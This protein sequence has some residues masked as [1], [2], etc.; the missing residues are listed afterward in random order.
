MGWVWVVG[1]PGWSG[2]TGWVVVRAGGSQTYP[3]PSDLGIMVSATQPADS[4]PANTVIA[5]TATT[6]VV[7]AVGATPDR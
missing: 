2:G 5:E 4:L 6:A 1:P 7:P 3:W